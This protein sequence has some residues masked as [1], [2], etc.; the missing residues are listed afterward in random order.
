MTL[1][2]VSGS[3]LSSTDELT[4][5]NDIG[6]RFLKQPF[7]WLFILCTALGEACNFIAYLYAPATMVAPLGCLSMVVT[8]ILSWYALGEKITSTGKLGIVLGI[9]GSTMIIVNAPAN[10]EI[11]SLEQ[12]VSDYLNQGPFIVYFTVNTMLAGTMAVL[13]KQHF[14]FRILLVSFL[15]PYV[16]ISAKDSFSLYFRFLL[17]LEISDFW[18]FLPA[19]IPP[20]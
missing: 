15:S 17:F 11:K 14:V 3:M 9:L 19:N 18:T 5:Q 7:W 6:Y 13:R 16:V 8:C 1:Q 2:T 20:I 12:L 10:T 4:P